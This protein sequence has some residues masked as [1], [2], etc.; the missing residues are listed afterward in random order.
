MRFPAAVVAVAAAGYAYVG[1]VGAEE[2]A[3]VGIG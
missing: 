2:H 1:R 3:S